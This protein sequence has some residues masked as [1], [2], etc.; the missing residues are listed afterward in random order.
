MFLY[1]GACAKQLQT[2]V[3]R[4]KLLCMVQCQ[5]CPHKRADPEGSCTTASH[6]ASH[7]LLWGYSSILIR[8][9]VEARCFLNSQ[10]TYHG[11]NSTLWRHAQNDVTEGNSSVSRF[12]YSHNSEV[13]GICQLCRPWSF[14][15]HHL[16]D[17]PEKI[18]ISKFCRKEQSATFIHTLCVERTEMLFLCMSQ[19]QFLIMRQ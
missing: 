12:F 8:T 3:C 13:V 9:K 2:C 11:I 1:L 4:H 17:W 7:C 6:R 15:V 16:A 5:D 19:Q 14:P 10:S 18:S